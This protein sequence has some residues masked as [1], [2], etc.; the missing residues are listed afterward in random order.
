[1]DAS[2]D[3]VRFPEC[4]NKTASYERG[5]RKGLQI[6]QDYTS[7]TRWAAG[8]INSLRLR[9]RIVDSRPRGGGLV[10]PFVQA[11]MLHAQAGQPLSRVKDLHIGKRHPATPPSSFARLNAP[12][13]VLPKPAEVS[14]VCSV[15]SP[16]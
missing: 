14:D 12:V 5:H 2:S 8:S 13:I 9:P 16:P 15:S 6:S 10:L 11:D 1:M 3:F 4:P 7:S